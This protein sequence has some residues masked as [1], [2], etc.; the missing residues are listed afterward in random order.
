MKYLRVIGVILRTLALIYFG[1]A[2]LMLLSA[3]REVL[4]VSDG[5]GAMV[6]K[7]YVVHRHAPPPRDEA[8]AL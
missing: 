6:C 3:P 1:V 8:S 4:C 7:A 2:V 5:D